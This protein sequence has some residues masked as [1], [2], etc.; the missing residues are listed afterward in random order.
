MPPRAK[1]VVVKSGFS[2]RRACPSCVLGVSYGLVLQNASPDVDALEIY[3]S[4]K[5]LDANGRVVLRRDNIVGPIPA[6]ATYYYGEDLDLSP[7]S[8][9]PTRLVVKIDRRVTSAK[10]SIGD[11]PPVA[12]I[13]VTDSSGTAH[14]LGEF[15]N[16]YT[17]TMSFDSY[18]TVV[19]FDASGNVIGG[20]TRD[21]QVSVPPGGRGDFDVTIYTLDASQIASA[22]ASVRPVFEF[23]SS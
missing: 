8:T 14:V 22:Q 15:T 6:A 3:Y 20:G 1:V 23:A 19:C 16:P 7:N 21:V 9:S 17:L 2:A 12:N 10:K 13:R 18:A 4:V 5:F 11:L